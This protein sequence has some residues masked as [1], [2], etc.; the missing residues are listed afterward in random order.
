M[1]LG[2]MNDFEGDCPFCGFTSPN[3]PDFE[4]HEIRDDVWAFVCN[5]CVEALELDYG[6]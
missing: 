1:A 2:T 3:M 5:L 4:L 6:K